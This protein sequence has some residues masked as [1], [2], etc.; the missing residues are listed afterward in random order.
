MSCILLNKIPACPQTQGIA[1]VLR[2][3]AKVPLSQMPKTLQAAFTLI[4]LRLQWHCIVEHPNEQNRRIIMLHKLY[5]D[6][7]QVTSEFLGVNDQYL[8]ISI[9]V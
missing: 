8:W 1:T 7:Y 4:S 5:R 2:G 3:Y 9:A 6:K